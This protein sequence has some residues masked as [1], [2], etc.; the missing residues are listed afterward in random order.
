M[1]SSVVKIIRGIV[2]LRG[3]GSVELSAMSAIV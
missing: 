1:I 2:K 3:T